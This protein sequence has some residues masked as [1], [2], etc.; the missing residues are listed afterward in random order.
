MSGDSKILSGKSIINETELIHFFADY[1]SSDKS[2]IK[3]LKAA[4]IN[5]KRDK[6]V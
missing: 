6:S 3:P 1:L 4:V 5:S 2:F